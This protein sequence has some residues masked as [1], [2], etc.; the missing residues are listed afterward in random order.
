[1]DNPRINSESPKSNLASIDLSDLYPLFDK[2]YDFLVDVRT[3]ALGSVSPL[4]PSWGT[5]CKVFSILRYAL[6][7][8]LCLDSLNLLIE[9]DKRY[10]R[11][12]LNNSDSIATDSSG[13]EE[14]MVKKKMW[15]PFIVESENFHD[16]ANT[17]LH[18]KILIDF[19][20]FSI[21]IEDIVR[22]APSSSKIVEK[23]LL[24]QYLVRVLEDD[25]LFRQT[26]YNRT[27][28]WEFLRE[29]V[30]SMLLASRKMNYRNLVHNC[31][32]IAS[33]GVFHEANI[34]LEDLKG[35]EISYFDLS[36]SCNV[37]PFY[38]FPEFRKNTCVAAQKFLIMIMELDLILKETEKSGFTSRAPILETIIGELIYN[39]NQILPFLEVFGEP[40][41]K[42]EM[43]LLYLGKYCKKDVHKIK[44]EYPDDWLMAEFLTL[45]TTDTKKTND[46]PCDGTL[47]SIMNFFSNRAISCGILREIT[48]E[49]ALFLVAQAFKCYLSLQADPKNAV[50]LTRMIGESTL[51]EVC[52]GL[53]ST[54][55]CICELDGKKYVFTTLELEALLLAKS[56]C[57]RL[58]RAGAYHSEII[59][60]LI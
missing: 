37:G 26:S 43:I 8:Q 6:P 52:S 7:I 58:T 25:Y 11:A 38:A 19:A 18:R 56:I 60:K 48:F 44:E 3:S 47:Q 54:F 53:I 1:M 51:L 42:L 28:N 9:L 31:M 57:R 32:L 50:F 4:P 46:S 39:K 30:V 5:Y 45:P 41:W 36:Q 40:K 12:H 49:V 55:Q 33:K 16:E 27:L 34:S 35:T 13:G 59:P 23:M 14:L 2:S 17:P 21:L 20:Y 22:G 29:S 24:F 15:F 10:P